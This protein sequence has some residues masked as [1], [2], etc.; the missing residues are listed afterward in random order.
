M[1]KEDIN[2]SDLRNL[3]ERE[4]LLLLNYKVGTIEKN[5]EKFETEFNMM[6]DKT[7]VLE[8]QIKS[9]AAF[10]GILTAAAVSTIAAI[11]T[12]FL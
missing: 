6:S 9:R 12:K 5:F 2:Q 11:A 10:W 1:S 3:T 7:I 8:E 4:L